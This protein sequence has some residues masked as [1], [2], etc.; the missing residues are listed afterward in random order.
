MMELS[1]LMR[2]YY[3]IKARYNDAILL[4]RVGDFYETFDED[5]KIASRELGI[6]LTSTS[7]GKGRRIPMAGVPCHAAAPYIKKLV[8]R[9]YRVAIC[10]QLEEPKGKD[11]VKRDVVRVI[12]PGTV[13]EETLLDERSSNY[14]VG[15]NF[16]G[17]RR[18]RT[19]MAIVDVSTGEFLVTEFEDDEEHTQLLNELARLRPAEILL[20]ASLFPEER[21]A[22]DIEGASGESLVSKLERLKNELGI[23][24]VTSYDDFYFDYEN[25]YTTLINHFKVVSLDGFGCSDMTAAVGAAGAVISYLRD[26][27]K[28]ALTHISSIR[29][30]SVSD[31]MVLDAITLRNLEIFKNLRDGSQRG[32]LLNVLDRTLTPMGARLLKKW[33]RFP[34][35]DVI[36]I[37]RRLDAVEELYDDALLRAELRDVLSEV[38]DVERIIGR[39]SYGSANARDLVALKKSLRELEKLKELLNGVRAEKLRAVRAALG[40]FSALVELIERGIV[41]SPPPTVKEGGIIKEGFN[42]ELD[43]LRRL[44]QEGRRWLLNFEERE[45]RRTGIKSLK[46]GYNK[47]FGYYI[48]VPRS[49]LRKVPPNYV[50]KQTLANAERFVTEELKDYEARV[51][52]AEERIKELEYAIFEEIRAEVARRAREIQSVAAAVAEL[53]V[54]LSFAEVAAENG[55]VRPEVH[56]GYDIVIE[57]GRHPVVELELRERGENFVPNDVHLSEENR[58]MI[59]TGPNMSGK[60]TFMRQVALITLLTQ[61]GSFVPASRAR[62]GVVDRIFTRVGAYDDLAMGQSSFMVEM[63]ETANILNNATERSLIILDEI[64]RG[65]STL[66]GVS[67]AWAVAEYIHERVR[68]KTMFATHFHELTALEDLFDGIKCYNVS[69]REEGGEIFFV[70][71]VVPGKGSKSYGIQ[72]ARLAGIPPAIIERAR[73]VMAEIERGE[74]AGTA[75]G[76]AMAATATATAT[77]ESRAGGTSGCGAA[78]APQPATS[79]EGDAGVKNAERAI[80]ELRALDLER[81][82]P[83]EALNKLYE[84]KRLLDE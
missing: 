67:I 42:E 59:I 46:V 17:G 79:G 81:M 65:T 5:A 61:I 25:A 26:T 48:E 84:L 76:A 60:S 27:Q 8:E 41:E 78:A 54:L 75:A 19:G 43:E 74:L 39:V 1:P 38:H 22:G 6:A 55:Y 47:V 7:R 57:G 10:E 20:P 32:T 71:K 4:F 21:C 58:L 3:R 31:F 37:N 36:E 18:V 23:G 44:K 70:R 24:G 62:V 11:V 64:G 68:A 35:L 33:L 28:S 16:G 72:V 51:L 69:V 34:L 29:T 73:A 49:Q 50:R 80:R 63:S 56:D 2:Q 30:F 45:R 83:I 14:L 82:T 9:G 13:F 40:D 66:D 12:T 77:A 15:V 53:D 52:G